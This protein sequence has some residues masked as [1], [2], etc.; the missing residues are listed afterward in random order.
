MK[1]ILLIF[2][3]AVVL[4]GCHPVS[5][6]ELEKKPVNPNLDIK[7]PCKSAEWEAITTVEEAGRSV[8]V[9]SR[10]Y[11][12]QG[13]FRLEILDQQT[14]NKQVILFDER[15]LYLLGHDNKAFMYGSDRRECEIFLRKIFINTGVSRKAEIKTDESVYNGQK[16]SVYEY[17]ILRNVNGLYAKAI[18]K[19]W[20][21]KKGATVKMEASVG[22]DEFEFS[23]KKV[24]VGPIKE[25][26]ETSGYKCGA[27]LMGM[28]FEVPLGMEVVNQ[29]ENYMKELKKAGKEKSRDS[30]SMTFTVK[31]KE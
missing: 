5:R 17:E 31:P 8:T 26:Y 1:K 4:A 29:H 6:E 21:N 28:L 13:K 19:E 30:G 11:F 20:R 10:V 3:T 14:G 7:I 16:C 23:G 22:P 9:K 2:F 27:R 12:R 18:I 24:I 15:N 25:T